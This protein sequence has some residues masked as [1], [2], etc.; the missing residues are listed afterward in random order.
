MTTLSQN[1]SLTRRQV[2]LENIAS[3]KW[4]LMLFDASCSLTV[5][6]CLSVIYKCSYKFVNSS[7]II[8]WTSLLSISTDLHEVLLC[9]L[10]LMPMLIYPANWLCFNH[11][12]FT[13]SNEV[14]NS[15][16]MELAGLERT[17][18]TLKDH[19]L[20]IKSITTDRHLGV[21]KY[22]R[23][24][25]PD[26]KHWFDVWHVAKGTCKQLHAYSSVPQFNV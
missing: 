7:P 10:Q 13:Q 4:K 23:E 12:I 16:A 15:Y 19:G 18:K 1:L 25:H 3:L 22:L 11:F 8:Y 14:K 17:L 9:V 26:I 21:K 24:Q 5:Q 2:K 20:D 6:L